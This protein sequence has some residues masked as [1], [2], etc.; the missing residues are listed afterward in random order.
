MKIIHQL[1]EYLILVSKLGW[2]A[3]YPTYERKIR[4]QVLIDEGSL[5]PSKQVA[6][7]TKNTSTLSYQH[8][9]LL[10]RVL[11]SLHRLSRQP[12]PK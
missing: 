4:T 10:A 1:L 5:Q 9:V 11:L 12:H 2:N 6:T 7:F 8:N 3:E